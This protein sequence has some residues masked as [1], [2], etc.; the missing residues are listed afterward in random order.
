[1]SVVVKQHIGIKN[2]LQGGQIEWY[3]QKCISRDRR[4]Q[5]KEPV[6]VNSRWYNAKL[7]FISVL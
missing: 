7:K 3:Q 1:M 5:C 2:N 4:L 6:Q